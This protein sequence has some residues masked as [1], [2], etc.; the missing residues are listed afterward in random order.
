MDKHNCP[1]FSLCRTG[2]VTCVDGFVL[3]SLNFADNENSYFTNVLKNM[4]VICI[5]C[6]CVGIRN[7]NLLQKRKI[8]WY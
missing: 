5:F 2:L 4:T 8:T 3:Q 7:T 6:F 1:F